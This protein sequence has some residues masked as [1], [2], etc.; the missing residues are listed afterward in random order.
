MLT[1]LI[2]RTNY[3]LALALI[4]R[5]QPRSRGTRKKFR[6]FDPAELQATSFKGLPV[7]IA[8]RSDRFESTLDQIGI[9]KNVKNVK[10]VENVHRIS[11]RNQSLASRP[12]FTIWTQNFAWRFP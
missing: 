5:P 8:D 7:S 10:I 3:A 9:S 12:F 1:S 4:P 2:T 6:D 11:Y